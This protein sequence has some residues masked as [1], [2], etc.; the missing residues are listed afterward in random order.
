MSVLTWDQRDNELA[1]HDFSNWTRLCWP[2]VGKKLHWTA[3]GSSVH[4][5]VPADTSLVRCRIGNSDVAHADLFKCL[6]S[7]LTARA[8]SYI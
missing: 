4:M 5:V 1:M 6:V 2:L 8:A 7:S 3:V